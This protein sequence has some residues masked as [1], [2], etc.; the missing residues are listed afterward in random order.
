MSRQ[1]EQPILQQI[2]DLVAE[3]KQ[4]R[5]HHRGGIGLN[6][7]ER[8]RLDAIEQELDRCW[9]LLRARRATEEF[10]DVSAEEDSAEPAEPTY[11]S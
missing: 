7:V 9:S 1:N 10:G 11:D 6:Q 4:L 2:H 8:G 5:A 3:E